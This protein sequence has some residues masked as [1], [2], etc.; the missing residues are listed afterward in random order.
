MR[1]RMRSSFG[2]FAA[3]CTIP[4][5]TK[6]IPPHQWKCFEHPLPDLREGGAANSPVG[7]NRRGRG[8]MRRSREGQREPWGSA[9]RRLRVSPSFP[10][11]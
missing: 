1:R 7:T 6:Q 8:R 2:S 9:R 11:G 4:P 3:A 10:N 5:L